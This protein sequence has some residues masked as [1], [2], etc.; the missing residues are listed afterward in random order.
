MMRYPAALTLLA[1]LVSAPLLAQSPMDEAVAA[2]EAGQPWLASQALRPV[3]AGPS[4][5]PEAVITAARAAAG[6]EGWTT[7]EGLLKG[8]SWLDQSFDRLGRRLLAEAALAGG[9]ASEALAHARASLPRTGAARSDAEQARRHLLIAR[10]HE[11]LGAWDSAAAA[12]THAAPLL[13][14]LSDWLA[15]RAAGVVRDSATRVRLY[16]TVVEPAARARIGWTEA[17]ALTRSGQRLK[18]ADR[19]ALLGD[20]GRALRLRWEATTEPARRAEITGEI[21]ALATAGTATADIRAALEMIAGYGI[22]MTTTDSLVVARRASAAG[23][24]AQTAAIMNAIGQARLSADDRFV[25]ASALADLGRWSDAA[26]V[27]RTITAGGRAGAAAY[28]AA[29]AEVRAGSTGAAIPALGR[30][31]SR[32]PG[33]TVAAGSALYLLAD[34]ALDAGLADSARRLLRRI[35]DDYPGSPFGARAM[36]IAPLIA[37]A[38]GDHATA[39]RELES[40]LG[41]R[42]LTGLDADAARYWLGRSRLAAGD[43]ASAQRHFRALLERGPE[44]YYALLSAGRLGT[45]PWQLPQESGEAAVG[46]PPP[47]ARAALLAELGLDTEAG[48]EIESFASSPTTP[49]E[50]KA[51]G[52][53]LLAAGHPARATRL[54]RQAA[55]ATGGR[56]G[57]IW[58]LIYPLP[59]GESLRNHSTAAGLDPWLVAALIRQESGFQP[60]A[61]S[62]AGARGLMQMMPDVGVATARSAGHPGLDPALLWQPDVNLGL[63]TRHFATAMSRYP[64]RERALAAYNAGGSRVTRWSATP[65]TGRSAGAGPIDDIELWVERIPYL[66]TRGYIR[67]IT[68]NEA[69]YRLLY[70]SP[71]QR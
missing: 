29:R 64:E 39:A 28:Q 38:N 56:D 40:H 33:D 4:P 31:P 25:L 35:A 3:L 14:Q 45:F 43:T 21:L 32:F 34:L 7:V 36:L 58:R 48:F 23:R 68:V 18:A 10:A 8:R 50:M 69:I 71:P 55:T 37:H 41:S 9:R 59:F 44:N 62:V 54:A 16:A 27:F 52:K 47:L 61:T 53:A 70:G 19:Y 60:H 12:Y 67:N 46:T 6:W 13:P 49:D 66:E 1:S 65:L 5:S 42:W 30:I 11:R 20:R 57:T 2:L 24:P 26:K 63:G 15:L 17:L 51:A 22:G